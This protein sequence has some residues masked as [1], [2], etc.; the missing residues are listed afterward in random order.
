MQYD[1]HL[2]LSLL[3]DG[4]ERAFELLYH[5]YSGRLYNFIFNITRRDAWL[6]EELV[7][8]AFIRIWECRETIDPEK[9]FISYL[10]TISKN[11]L[12]NEMER[13]AVEFVFNEYLMRTGE[14]TDCSTDAETDLLLL[15]NVIEKLADR[16]PSKRRRIF[17]L[18][19]NKDYSVKEIASEL[20]LAS[21]TVSAQLT[22]ALTFMRCEL[23][24]YYDLL[25][26]LLTYTLL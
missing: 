17:L 16:L 20:N 12:L 21:T 23:S 3:K 18:R 24:K 8:R 11:M 1:D 14:K 9:S 5:R 2:C 26:V 7:Q 13:Q 19:K 10:C 4:S 22:K 15:E 6:T 25:L